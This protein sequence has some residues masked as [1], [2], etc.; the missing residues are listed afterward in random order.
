MMYKILMIEDNAEKDLS[1]DNVV[2]M[3]RND[4]AEVSFTKSDGTS[5]VMSC[6]LLNEVLSA[7]VPESA[8]EGSKSAKKTPNPNTVAVF[9]LEADGW[10]SFRLDSVKSIG[11]PNSIFTED[12][13]TYPTFSE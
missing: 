4:V 9:D 6:T 11:F 10:R 13:I 5:R 7:R 12:G 2:E 8:T 1:R 3:L